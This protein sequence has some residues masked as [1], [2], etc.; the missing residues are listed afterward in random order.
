MITIKDILLPVCIEVSSEVTSKKAALQRLASLLAKG[1]PEINPAQ[2]FDTLIARERLGSTGLGAGVAIPHGRVATATRAIGA[3]ISTAEGIDYDAIDNGE[4]DLLFALIV[5]ENA[6]DTHLEILAQLAQLFS[7]AELLRRLR[8]ADS[9]TD[10][11]RIL[12]P[13]KD[14]Y[15]VAG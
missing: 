4:V 3:F 2:V 12:I 7:D 1:F 14:Q 10:V 8:A 15:Q 5:P 6:T 9:V 13:L 11:Q